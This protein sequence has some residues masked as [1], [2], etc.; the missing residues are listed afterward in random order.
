MSDSIDKITIKLSELSPEQRQLLQQI[1][2]DKQPESK[3]ESTIN[4][5]YSTPLDYADRRHQIEE[6]PLSFSQER[7]WFFEQFYQKSCTYNINRRVKLRGNLNINALEKALKT[8]IQR[9]ES[10]KTNFQ[11]K[12]GITLQ[13]IQENPQFNL[14]VIDLNNFPLNQKEEQLD[15][16]LYEEIRK[17][18]N[19][20]EDLMLR[21]SLYCL[22][23]KEYIFLVIMHHIASDG[24]SLGVFTQ[25]LNQLYNAFSKNEPNI[26]PELPLQY[27]DFSLWQRN[28]YQDE[29]LE[30]QLNYWREKF[31]GNIPILNLPNDRPRPSLETFNGSLYLLRISP[32]LTSKLKEVS[33]QLK[34]TLFMILLTAFKI[35]L[36]RYTTEEDIILGTP[37]AG[38]NY[39]EIEKLIGFF[40]N[41]LALKTNLSGNPTF[42][43]LLKRVQQTAQEAYIHQELPY[44]KLIQELELERDLSRGAL[45]QVLFSFQ[46]T[47]ETSLQLSGLEVSSYGILN[48]LDNGTARCDLTVFLKEEEE[49]IRGALEYNTDLFNADRIKRLVAHFQVLLAG[50]IENPQQNISYLPLLTPEEKNQLL[51]EWNQTKA[52]YPKDK[53]IHQLFEEQVTKTPNNIAVVFKEQT[54]TYQQ[55]NEKANQLAHY[56][57]KLGVQPETKVGICLQRSLDMIIGILGILKAGGAYVPL[58]PNYPSNRLQFLIE[59]ASIDILL[60]QKSLLNQLPSKIATILCL[61]RANPIGEQQKTNTLSKVN[62]SNLAYV[63]YTSGSTG[64]PKGVEIPH[65]NVINIL[66]SI[67]NHLQVSAQ[68]ILLSLATFSFD[69][70]VAEI[71]LPLTNGGQ[72]IIPPETII[73]DAEKLKTLIDQ[74]QATIIDATP[75]TWKLLETVNWQGKEKLKIISTGEKLSSELANYLLAKNKSVWNIYG[76]TECTIWSLIYQITTAKKVLIGKPLGNTQT[77]ILDRDLNPVPIGIAGELHI[78]GDGLAR[79]YLNRRELTAERFIDNPFGAGKLYKTGDLA[80]YLADGNI[81][82]LGRIDNQVKIRGFRIELGEIE[83][84]LLQ[85]PSIKETL[86]IARENQHR[87]QYLTAYLIPKDE[88]K[89]EIAQLRQFLQEK[90]PE[91]MIPSAF[92]FLDNFPLTPNGKINRKALPEPDFQDNRTQ[93]F[94]APSNQ[95]EIKL[96]EI[97]QEVLNIEKVGINDNFF[98]LGGH[99]LLAIRS[100]RKII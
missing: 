100:Q 79:G 11:E 92:V 24:W 85:H 39:L 31:Q 75:A 27:A 64:K 28:W 98:E 38:R 17:P 35:L 88:Q 58:D 41:T 19:L 22:N 77:Y 72:L 51:V 70:S 57:Q 42:E 60:S 26:L 4:N 74:S 67:T 13:E 18:F 40:V 2:D 93:K 32:N 54:L 43:E 89:L 95:T 52:E 69:I 94:I 49:E 16:L 6:L 20:S 87:E 15:K 71:F 68:D 97:W 14:T 65:S 30:S 63:I 7:L 55:L 82:F 96:A 12:N 46:N 33:K 80:R 47:P 8:I 99:S 21:A 56:L 59:D 10:L 61:D 48:A 25:E 91:Y 36:Y 78:A 45:T 1:L 73:K 83:A 23:E 5:N 3:K 29:K 76:P 66:N 86:V 81:E 90:L 9:H 84:N 62:S 53:C 37:I 34:V 44:E 50:I